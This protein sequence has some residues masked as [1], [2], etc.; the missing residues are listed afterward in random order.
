ME[1]PLSSS[2]DAVMDSLILSLTCI[3]FNVL[4]SEFVLLR[5]L[6]LL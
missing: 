5:G 4:D 3:D 6:E 2:S 1:F